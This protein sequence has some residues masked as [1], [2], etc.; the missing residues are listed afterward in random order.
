[1]NKIW[2]IIKREYLTRVKK[3][4]FLVM[5]ILGPLLMASLMIVP[6]IVATM[7]EGPKKVGIVDQSGFFTEA[8]KNSNALKFSNLYMDIEQAKRNISNLDI[9]I[10]LFIPKPEYSYPTEIFLYSKKQP[11]MVVE[12][13]IRN[14]INDDLRTLRMKKLG[15]TRD[16]L[17]QLKTNIGV[18]SIK[19]ND[20]G[21]EEK[22]NSTLKFI[23]GLIGGIMIYFFI[24]MYGAQ[25][26]R[27]VI[28]E[29]TSRIVEVIISSVRPFQLMMG[30]IIGVAMVGMTQFLLWVAFTSVIVFGFQIAFKDK[31][32]AVS[33][34]KMIQVGQNIQSNDP[35]QTTGVSTDTSEMISAI[36]SINYGSVILSFA[37]FFL[38]GYLI[39]AALFAA[40]GAAVDNE[41]D[42]QQFMMPI[43]VP[44]IL[45]LTMSQF[46]ANNPDGQF[47]FWL[48][49]IPF[50]SPIAMMIRIPFGVDLWQVFLSGILLVGTF[51]FA[52]YFAAKIYRTGILIYGKKPSYKELWKWFTYKSK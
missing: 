21:T 35:L 25:V 16:V 23:L 5:T 31:L 50:T 51:V 45:A 24:F 7:S 2:L 36:M 6:V 15:V 28:E 19:L 12:S 27:G 32:N 42:T 18:N 47:A 49:I 20:D 43:T 44:M 14:T 39:Y 52:T 13:L 40:I 3:K 1:M 26:M 38:F 22:S 30:K 41:T 33:A 37:F 4:S 8:F 11:G 17:E 34:E 46:I 48:S 29:K 9:D 10:I